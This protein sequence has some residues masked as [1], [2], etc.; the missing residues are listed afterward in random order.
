M[1][2]TLLEELKRYVRFDPV[3]EAALRALHPIAAPEFERIST[4]FYDRILAHEEARKALEGGESRV[5]HLKVTLVAW[6][7][8]L[9]TG[10]WDE[11]Y[12][13]RRCRIG[14]I[15]VRIALPQHYM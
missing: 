1:A 15:H 10:P 2:E 8:G 5:G 9:L 7:E 4:V 14:R 11:A 12:Y 13:E 3:D 6:M